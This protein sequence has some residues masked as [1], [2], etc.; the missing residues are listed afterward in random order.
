MGTQYHGTFDAEACHKHEKVYS[1][2]R[3]D[4][5]VMEERVGMGN[6][7]VLSD[8]LVQKLQAFISLVGLSDTDFFD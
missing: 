2:R 6:V 4:G 1:K 7:W 5:S 8:S 3:E